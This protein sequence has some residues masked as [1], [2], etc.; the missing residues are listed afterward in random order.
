MGG[1]CDSG[2]AA[3]Q[4]G[5]QGN[6]RVLHDDRFAGETKRD[7]F[8]EGCQGWEGW[9]GTNVTMGAQR[10]L[11]RRSDAVG[12][13]TARSRGQQWHE[14]PRGSRGQGRGRGLEGCSELARKTAVR[15]RIG[16][17]VHDDERSPVEQLT[18]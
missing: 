1:T 18:E 10:G 5:Q 15:L 14:V 7:A 17:A 3:G 9:T 13:V 16:D 12:I 8:T 4:Q 11:Y 6:R 2:L